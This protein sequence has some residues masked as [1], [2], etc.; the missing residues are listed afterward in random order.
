MK[1]LNAFEEEKVLQDLNERIRNCISEEERHTLNNEAISKIYEAE[2]CN[3]CGQVVS[4]LN[5]AGLCGFCEYMR[6]DK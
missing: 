4:M 3:D 6:G 5:H 1:R 2:A